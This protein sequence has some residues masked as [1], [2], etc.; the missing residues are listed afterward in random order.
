MYVSKMNLRKSDEEQHVNATL[1]VSVRQKATADSA[2]ASHNVWWHRHQLGNL[3]GESD[4]LHDC[5]QE[6]RNRVQRDPVSDGD[7]HVYPDLPVLE[8][9]KDELPLELV[10]KVRG[11]VLETGNDGLAFVF[12]QKFGCGGIV[13]H[14]P[15]AG[16]C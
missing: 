12:G 4:A 2:Y 15:V 14:D 16:E 8:G 5:R 11:I 3:V 13:V 10:R 6:D 9:V 7:E 1:T